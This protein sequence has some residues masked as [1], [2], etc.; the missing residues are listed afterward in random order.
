[1]LTAGNKRF[2][3]M[4]VWPFVISRISREDLGE[5]VLHHEKIHF[6]Q[7]LE[8][9]FVFFF[10]WYTLEY[11]IRWI[12]LKNRYNAYRTIS[13]EKEAYENERNQKYLAV[14]KPFVWFKYI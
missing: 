4:A 2:T 10:I 1:V 13:F 9:L 11:L 6:R 8:M 7:Q 3:A 12:K 5:T 14:R